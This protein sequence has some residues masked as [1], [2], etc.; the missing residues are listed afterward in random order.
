[1]YLEEYYMYNYVYKCAVWWFTGGFLQAGPA[2]GLGPFVAGIEL[3]RTHFIQARSG[4]NDTTIL[5]QN[6]M[7]E[8]FHFVLRMKSTFRI[9]KCIE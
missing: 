5:R 8:F 1:M 6:W 2:V 9:L 3:V 4:K 7:P